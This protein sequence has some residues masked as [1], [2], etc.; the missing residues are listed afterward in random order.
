[1]SDLI[2][3]RELADLVG[4]TR[5]TVTRWIRE[6]RIV[7]AGRLPGGRYRLRREQ[8]DE[9]LAGGD[10]VARAGEHESYIRLAATRLDLARRQG[11]S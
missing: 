9:I 3:T 2:T 4:V 10:R 6:G 8:A 11:R 1:M 7:P 5:E